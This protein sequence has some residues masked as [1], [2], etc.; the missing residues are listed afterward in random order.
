[1]TRTGHT[2]ST[3]NTVAAL[4]RA[5]EVHQPALVILDSLATDRADVGEDVAKVRR[6]HELGLL[7]LLSCAESAPRVAALNEG[8]DDCLSRPFS[9]S[10]LVA[11]SLAVLRRSDQ[12]AGLITIGDLVIDE[13]TGSVRR[14]S[15]PITLTSTE[16]KILLELARAPGELASKQ[17]LLDAVWG[18]QG[19]DENVVE[20]HISSLRKR[21]DTGG[22]RLIHT[23]RG[24]G[25]K[26]SAC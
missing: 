4:P 23:V 7:V 3:V 21:L 26:L 6:C 17:H 12:T 13:Q 15:T 22:P 10:E 19:Y 9:F 2:L 8:A 20:V 16:R 18:Y 11:R 25:Y 5:V 1:M 14:G 24:Q